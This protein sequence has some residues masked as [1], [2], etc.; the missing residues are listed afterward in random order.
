M[1]GKKGSIRIDI[2]VNSSKAGITPES[3]KKPKTFVDQINLEYP[4]KWILDVWKF[5]K[6]DTN[7]VV[8]ALKVGLACLLV[9]LLILCRAPYDIFGANIIWSILTVAIMF[10]YTVG[11]T[12]NKGFNRA[13]GSLFAGIFAIVVIQIAMSSGHIAEPYVIGL[14]IFLIG[15]ITSFMKLWPSFVPYEYGFRVTLFTYCLIIV[16]GYR[17]GNPIRTAMDRLYSIAI[18]GLVAV[19]VNVLVCPIWAGEQLHKELVNNFNSLADSLEECVKKYLSDDG[20]EHP[21]FTKTVMDDFPDEPAFRKCR[22]SLNFSSKLDSLANSAKWEPPHGRFK[23]FFYPWLEYVKVGAVLRHCAY[24]VMALHGC[25]HSEI[26]APYNL[27]CTFQAEILDATNQA[28]EL[29]RSLGKDVN[30]M[31][32]SLHSNLLNRVHSSTEHLQHSIDLH[33]YLLTSKLPSKTFSFKEKDTS[34]LIDQQV[35]LSRENSVKKQHKRMHSWP[36][37]GIDEGNGENNGE[38]EMEMVP[39][40]RALES[41]ACLSLATFTSLLIELVARLDH[42]VEAVDRLAKMAKFKQDFTI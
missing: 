15:A 39:R 28:A 17:M 23:H 18:G 29:L 26:Q 8:F 38:V 31:K 4:S 33:S 35:E 21:E 5:A 36:P 24:E 9:S 30:I 34:Q 41:T 40:M 10:E 6:D 42:L 37:R 13:L 32:W 19:L 25:L 3:L 1:N 22:A 16:S 14:S 20:S 27:R 11:A 2:H 12:F 7:R